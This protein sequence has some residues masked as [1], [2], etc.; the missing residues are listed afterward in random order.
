MGSG[1]TAVGRQLARLLRRPFVDADAELV[2]RTGVEI[3]MI[4]EKEGESGF[5]ERERL[6]LEELTL[7]VG[8]VLSTGGGAI[9]DQHTREFLRTRGQ[10]VYLQTSVATQAARV[11]AGRNRP[12]LAGVDPAARLQ[13]LMHVRA[14]LYESIAHVVV[15]TDGRRV[16]A[17]ADDVLRRLDLR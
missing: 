3:P 13:E 8:I 14:P 6:L 12:M 10:V 9:L 17:V 2:A 1:K 4:F 16:R 5:R 7:R 15:T 11:R